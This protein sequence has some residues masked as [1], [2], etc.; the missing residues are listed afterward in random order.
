MLIGYIDAE[1]VA[2]CGEVGYNGSG[3]VNVEG[4]IPN[5][6]LGKLGAECVLGPAAIVIEVSLHADD[7]VVTVVLL[8]GNR[9]CRACTRKAGGECVPGGSVIVTPL[10]TGSVSFSGTVN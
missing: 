9:P 7:Q 10:G 1:G 8:D 2:A 4:D 3:K 5:I 6:V